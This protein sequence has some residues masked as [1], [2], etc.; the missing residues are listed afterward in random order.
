MTRRLMCLLVLATFAVLVCGPSGQ[1]RAEDAKKMSLDDA[2]KAVAAYK[3]GQSRE[4]QTVVEDAVRD[5]AAKPDDRAALAK[6]LAGLLS[7][8]DATLDAKQFACRQ[9]SI[10]GTAA[11]VPAVA[12]LLLDKDLSDYA[13][14][15]LERIPLPEAVAAIRAAMPKAT[16]RMK[17]GLIN[18]L[19][20]RRDAESAPALAALLQDKDAMIAGAAAAALGKIGGA[21]AAKALADFRGKAPAELKP[22]VTDAYLVA[23]DQFVK[24]GKKDAAEAIYKEVYVPT[25]T[26]AVRVAALAGLVATQGEKSLA[27]LAPLMTGDDVQ[28]QVIAL[29]LAQ[30]IPG[31]EATKALAA[32]L[33]KLPVG[34]QITLAG[35]L[36][37]RGDAAAAPAL[38]EASK[39]DN[40]GVRV[41]A[42]RALGGV[43]DVST[44]AVLIKAAVGPTAGAAID[45]L[46]RL[47]GA[48][49]DAALVKALDG[50][51]VP[52]KSALLQAL[53]ARRAASAVPEVVKALADA[54]AGIRKTAA[55]AL[56]TMGDD[57]A[58]AALI[59]FASKAEKQDE[60]DAAEKALTAICDRAADKGKCGL[61]IVEASAAAKGPA[62]VCFLKVMPKI[63][64]PSALGAIKTA[65]ADADAPTAEAALRVLADWPDAA[66]APD[67][68][69]VAKN[70]QNATFQVLALRGYIRLA[71]VPAD[72]PAAD[73]LKMLKEALDLAKRPDEKK[74]ALASLGE[75]G[76]LDSLKLVDPCIDDKGLC[77]EA[78][79]A[80]V[81]IGGK[82]GG[83]AEAKDV[84]ATMEKV[85][86]N[87]KN[88]NIQGEARK[89]F[90]NAKKQQAAL[91]ASKLVILAA[92]T[93]EATKA[94]PPKYDT[95]GAEKLGWKL[96]VQAWSFNSFTF[97]EAIDKTAA[98]GLHYIEG[99]PGQKLTKDPDGPKGGFDQGMNDETI[100]AV[101]KK[102]DAAGV[103]VINFGVCGV[104]GD[105]AGA[106]KI[107]DWAKKM[108]IETLVTE[109]DEKDFPLLSKLCDEYKINIA[110][111]NHPKES[112]YWNPDTVLKGIEGQSKRI[113][114]CS[115]TGHWVRS[116]L[117]PVEC[118]KK[119][120]GHVISLHFKDLADGHD[121]PWG[122]GKGDVKGQLAELKR[123]GFKGVFSIE[124]EHNWGKNDAD[125][126]NCAEF[127]FKTANE[128]AAEK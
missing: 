41:A 90:D 71:S 100:A 105:E 92:P 10:I 21:D 119:L 125:M 115:D 86:Q 104:P 34:A 102:L 2:F 83:K 97:Y 118:L 77:E 99:I 127:F 37:E 40:E 103:K 75:I 31:A 35:Q 26:K 29:R 64:G 3:F 66:A 38:I 112:H 85:L 27:T 30:G 70:N 78:C 8:A 124:Y 74:F 79:Q 93:E 49:V 36:G 18:T 33:P 11:E 101:K 51:D 1:A 114:S 123:Q 25:E 110:L 82:L 109:S 69:D 61:P 12:A 44:V 120:E 52:V 43:G 126:A 113:G 20:V 46:G 94:E 88:K 84:A 81:K 53:A 19:G 67:L 63:G 5:S 76:T 57:K 7:A 65:L 62:K 56:G 23:A 72:R 17:V 116:G 60:L 106:R 89:L 111:H 91:P 58:V 95:T 47:K 16:E 15:A 50:A 48:D 22:V 128:L 4:C 13:R 42:L 98:I 39:G 108:G 59:G 24:N 73:K 87:S 80:A 117:V 55:T 122:T 14:Y 107:F 54:D 68:L 121:V 96:A 45:A 6:R 32:M 28:M 9:I